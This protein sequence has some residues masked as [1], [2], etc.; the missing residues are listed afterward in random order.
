MKKNIH[1]KIKRS[2]LVKIMFIIGIILFLCFAYKGIQYYSQEMYQKG[3][4]HGVNSLVKEQTNSNKV[5]LFRDGE[6][7]KIPLE[8]I[9]NN[10]NMTA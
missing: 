7:V 10:T 9:C 5:F 1:I 8:T 6:M 3:A 4:S 2:T